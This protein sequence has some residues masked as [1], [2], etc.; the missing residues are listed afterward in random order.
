MSEYISEYAM[1]KE[2]VLAASEIRKTVFW[3]NM[4]K[5]FSVISVVEPVSGKRNYCVFARSPF[6]CM[7]ICE[8]EEA[9]KAVRDAVILE[10]G[11]PDA[12][13]Y[14]D[15]IF[16]SFSDIPSD[17]A[18]AA[19]LRKDGI[20][21]PGRKS[22]PEFIRFRALRSP[23]MPDKYDADS[24]ALVARTLSSASSLVLSGGYSFKPV[25]PELPSFSL[26]EGGLHSG[27]E[28]VNDI[29]RHPVFTPE[30]DDA[31]RNFIGSCSFEN[32]DVFEA[33]LFASPFFAF[34]DDKG[35]LRGEIYIAASHS[36][37][38]FEIVDS[39]EYDPDDGPVG[40]A[41][42]FL[43]YIRK[44]GRIPGTLYARNMKTAYFL[45]SIC[46]SLGIRIKIAHSSP[47]YDF[48]AMC[49]VKAEE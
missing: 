41:D 43:G 13:F 17:D 16:L 49:L 22:F 18:F 5:R 1:R 14:I 47:V 8:S 26:E 38:A 11:E 30:S 20:R 3:K 48:Y 21:F 10:T 7:Y 36:E 29:F 9:L 24:V 46:E 23:S 31:V 27:V 6:K 32:N 34:E 15:A 19:A 2:L 25:F 44:T 37:G 28:T 45:S 42:S 35:P 4:Q 40:L 39:D 12:N 33:A